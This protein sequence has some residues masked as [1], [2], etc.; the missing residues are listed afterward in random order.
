[1]PNEASFV[2]SQTKSNVVVEIEVD[3]SIVSNSNRISNSEVNLSSFCLKDIFQNDLGKIEY[4]I[5]IQLA[6]TTVRLP[7]VV[8][9]G[10][11]FLFCLKERNLELSE[12]FRLE[13]KPHGNYRTFASGDNL[14]VCF[15]FV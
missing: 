3:N 7:L 5:V 2:A 4:E 10:I 15:F 1:M 11:F 13:F 9:P 12:F 14:F 8:S 6:Q